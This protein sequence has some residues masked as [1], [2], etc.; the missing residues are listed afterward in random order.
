MCIVFEFLKE[1]YEVYGFDLIDVDID[2]EV[3][4]IYYKVVEIGCFVVV[5]VLWVSFFIVVEL[6]CLMMFEIVCCGYDYYV[7]DVFEDDFNSF[8]GF[9]YWVFGFCMVVMYCYGEFDCE[10]WCLMM[11]FNIFDVFC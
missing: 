5:E 6:M 11:L 1:F 2:V 10:S 3:F 7:I 9:Y 4:L 8:Y